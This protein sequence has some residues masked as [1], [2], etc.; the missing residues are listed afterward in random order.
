LES[1]LKFGQYGV[2][3]VRRTV[4]KRLANPAIGP[5][6]QIPGIGHELAAR[7]IEKWPFPYEAIVHVDEWDQ[8]EG[9]SL[10][11]KNIAIKFLT[12]EDADGPDEDS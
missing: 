7:I 2:L 9:I 1:E 5:L 6:A 3:T 12:G 11:K 8:V 4:D 10:K